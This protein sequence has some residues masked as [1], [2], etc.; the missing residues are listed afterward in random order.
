MTS[1]QQASQ[2][3]MGLG[4]MVDILSNIFHGNSTGNSFLNVMSRDIF[5]FKE[6]TEISLLKLIEK[7]SQKFDT[8]KEMLLTSRATNFVLSDI[9]TKID[10]FGKQ[11]NSVVLPSQDNSSNDLLSKINSNVKGIFDKISGKEPDTKQ[12]TTTDPKK[13]GAGT[14]FEG[15][16][17]FAESLVLIKKNLTSRLTKNVT[18]FLKSFDTTLSQGSKE[19]MKIFGESMEKFGTILTDLEKKI[20]GPTRSLALLSISFLVLSFAII[21]PTFIAGIAILGGF[22]L[23]MTK[24][25]GNKE[26]APGMINFG[27][28]ILALTAALM[29]MQFVKWESTVKL[30]AFIGG[31]NLVLRSF[32]GPKGM[33]TDVKS[34]PML[35]FA[36]GIAALTISM[37]I[38]QF[39]PWEAGAKMILFIGGLGLALKLFS[40]PNGMGTGGIKNSP[41]IAFAMGIAILTL[42]LFAINEVPWTSI[43]KMIFFIGALGL[44]MKLFNFSKMGPT[45]GMIGFALGLGLFILCILAFDEL[46]WEAMFKTILFIGALGLTMKLFNFNKMGPA[47][48]MISFAFGFAIMVLA[49]YAINELPWEA[50][51][52]T[53]LFIGGLGLVMKLFGSTSGLNFLALSAG[54]L[55]LSGALYVFKKIGWTIGDAFTFGITVAI[56]AGVVA[57]AGIPV[58]S[59]A[60]GLGSLAIIGMSVSLL[61]AGLSLWAISNMTLNFENLKNFG[62]AVGV[63]SLAMAAIAPFAV[64]GLVGALAVLPIAVISIITAIALWTISGL[65]ITP[66]NITNFQTAITGLTDTYLNIGF[67]VIP[68]AAASLLFLPIALVSIIGV[69]ALKLVSSL[70]INNANIVK[71][72]T[73]VNTLVESINSVGMWDLAKTGAKS[74]LLLP[75]FGSALLGGLVLRLISGLNIDQNKINVFGS[76]LSS[77]TS[78][79]A[80]VLAENEDKLAAAQPGI[81]ALAKLMSVSSS[82]ARTIQLMANMQFYEYGVQDGKLVLKGV[83][84]LTAEDFVRVG[85]NLG[86][87]LRCLIEPLTILGSNSNS[88]VIGG[89]V[90]T[91]PF[92][93]STALKGIEM[94]AAVG[95]AFK[96]LAESVKT[97]ASIPMVSNP[98]LLDMFRNSL[99]VMVTTFMWTFNKLS[100][101]DLDLMNN[102]IQTIVKFIDIF[103]G[104]DTQKITALNG[105]FEKFMNNL[106]N[107]VKWKKIN[108]NLNILK[109]NF[110]DIAKSINSID[111]NKATVFERNIKN[112]INNNN[113]ESLRKAVESLAELLNMIKENQETII[114][115]TSTAAPSTP[116]APG[117]IATPGSILSPTVATKKPA[118]TKGGAENFDAQIVAILSEI[119]SKVGVTNSKLETLKVRVIGNNSNTV[120]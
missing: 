26:I 104:A 29:I 74:L 30:L 63:L 54:I 79:I 20:K 3:E 76:T 37:L 12:E 62:I 97:Y 40:G 118:A 31:L 33:G 4:S 103:K 92:K 24:M 43:F 119:A 50:L 65:N 57:L 94:L 25:S 7:S 82:L 56:L 114:S 49:M 28:G 35:L 14:M 116:F 96:P 15:I 61:V 113:S 78:T 68:A 21:S 73:G 115:T 72:G 2:I 42:T 105:I 44:V 53:L 80:G 100:T 46:P 58:I 89:Q 87:M 120:G 85:Q 67:S 18:N 98:K 51:A 41:M 86:T 60:I 39:V 55:V 83:R 108:Q 107:D 88:F 102:G 69:M 64:I 38:M 99:I 106:S 111:I 47:N 8:M 93:S 34:S 70:E 90:I 13:L 112:L 10:T 48:S 109:K 45:N 52:K 22:I 36:I 84:T 6:N 77:F 81:H 11:P 110:Q 16:A 9:L 117:N 19:K 32:S 75:I 23:L 1:S 17:Q 5:N 91:N 95:N 66:E 101:I 27:L 71:Y 59:A